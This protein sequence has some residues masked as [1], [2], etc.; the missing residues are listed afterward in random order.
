MSGWTIRPISLFVFLIF[1]R[2][3]C[4]FGNV[5]YF[6]LTLSLRV[7]TFFV[8]ARVPTVSGVVRFCWFLCFS[9]GVVVVVLVHSWVRSGTKYLVLSNFTSDTYFVQFWQLDSLVNLVCVNWIQMF[10]TANWICFHGFFR[11]NFSYFVEILFHS[12]S[13]MVFNRVSHFIRVLLNLQAFFTF[14]CGWIYLI[15]AISKL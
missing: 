7:L 5:F 8:K 1:R 3:I 11:I 4:F 12:L 14:S 15:D 9:Y 13:S 6:L 2:L 10:R